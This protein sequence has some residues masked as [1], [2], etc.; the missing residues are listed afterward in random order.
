MV[1]IGFWAIAPDDATVS[2]YR[3]SVLLVVWVGF[4]A[5]FRG[6]SDLIIGFR[7]HSA[8]KALDTPNPA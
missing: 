4:A 5:L 1:L 7:L 3:G 2:T 8:H 6:I